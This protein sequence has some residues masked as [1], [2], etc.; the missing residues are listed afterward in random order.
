MFRAKHTT[1]HGTNQA[2]Y[3]TVALSPKRSWAPA[4]ACKNLTQGLSVHIG[5]CYGPTLN[6]SETVTTSTRVL[7]EKGGTKA[8]VHVVNS[9]RGRVKCRSDRFRRPAESPTAEVSIL[10]TLKMKHEK[11]FGCFMAPKSGVG[12]VWKGQKWS[13]K[14][15]LGVSHGSQEQSIRMKHENGGGYFS[16][17]PRVGWEEFGK[18]KNEA[19]KGVWVFLMVP[20]SERG[21]GKLKMKHEKGGEC[22]SWFPRVGWEE[23]KASKRGSRFPRVGWEGLGKAQNEAW[24]RVWV[25]HGSQAWGGKGLRRP[26]MKHENRVACFMVPKSGVGRAWKR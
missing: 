13:M 21:F 9:R 10:P 26:R 14:R 18:A 23:S 1:N 4:W 19:W 3:S 5:G 12:R 6:V 8:R 2:P 15:G 17:I 11:G 24:K 7:P 22:F 16:W 20:K 25:L